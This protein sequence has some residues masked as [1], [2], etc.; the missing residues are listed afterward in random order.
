MKARLA[1]LA[2]LLGMAACAEATPSSS[3]RPLWFNHRQICTASSINQRIGLWLTAHHCVAGGAP[4]VEDRSDPDYPLHASTVVWVS[5]ADDLAVLYTDS[6]RVPALALAEAGP[7]V[8]ADVQYFG[9]PLG[10]TTLQ[11]AKGYLSA[12]DT[13]V[14]DDD[15]TVDYGRHDMFGMPTCQGASGSAILDAEGRL[16]SVVQLAPGA[17]C[18]PFV[19]GARFERLRQLIARFFEE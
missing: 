14:T 10:F 4:D 2:V 11:F 18:S 9:Y 15:G 6:L 16:V 7:E 3:V 5:V 17:P 1:I 13:H 8:G 12:K 19:G